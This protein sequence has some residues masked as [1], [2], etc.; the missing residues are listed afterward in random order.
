MAVVYT[1]W[2]Q[3]NFRVSFQNGYRFPTL[4]EG[5][6]YVNNG[7]VRRLGGFRQVSE[8][9]QAF[10]N[11]YI[12]GSVTAFKNA[13]NND[14]NNNGLSQSDAINKEAGVLVKSTYD[15]IQPEH[16]NSFEVGYKGIFFDNKVY[17][18]V[19]YY[20]SSYDHFIGQLDI[21]QPKS[22]TIGDGVNTAAAAQIYNGQVT[23]FKMWTNSKSK[24]T[25]QGVELGLT[26]NFF[27]KFNL[28]GNASY[29]DLKSVESSDAFTPAF[30]TPSWITNV[31]IGNR[32]IAKNVGFNVGWH[33]QNSFYWNSPL[34]AGNVPAYS[35]VD[36]QVNYRFT[37]QGT[38]IKLGATNILNHKYYQY[39]GGP[40]IGG[41][42]YA[43]IVFDTHSIHK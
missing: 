2:E 37:K 27:R 19:D 42:Y 33:W 39:L 21:T 35:T 26:Y 17:L 31:S 30:N 34:A 40:S 22:T 10:E 43:T 29:A 9:L 13:V 28:T 16:I 24:V 20:L 32:E 5:F 38:I 14:V 12:N 7:G 36:A 25:N 23:K 4:F 15:Y 18:D 6:A 41:F 3:H 8:H 11:S 1:P